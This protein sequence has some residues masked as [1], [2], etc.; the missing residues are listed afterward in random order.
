MRS[1]IDSNSKNKNGQQISTKINKHKLNLQ[2]INTLLLIIKKETY[3]GRIMS[4]RTNIEAELENRLTSLKCLCSCVN[5][6][7]FFF[8]RAL[9][10]LPVRSRG[11]RQKSS[12]LYS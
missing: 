11:R 4:W 3:L 1:D 9:R 2:V 6:D 8:W 10:L 7:A 12:I 5:M